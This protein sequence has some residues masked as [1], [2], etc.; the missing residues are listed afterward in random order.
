MELIYKTN[1]NFNWGQTKS[2]NVSMVTIEGKLWAIHSIAHFQSKGTYL[3]TISLSKFQFYLI[4][5]SF[6]VEL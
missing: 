3:T 5:S 1:I 6:K 2:C 4:E